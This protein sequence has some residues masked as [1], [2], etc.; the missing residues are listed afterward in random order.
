M[1][2]E[3]F[4]WGSGGSKDSLDRRRR[5]AEALMLRG[6]DTSPVQHWTQ[7]LARVG[8]AISGR[9][10][11]N[12][13]DNEAKAGQ[14]ALA[15][16]L[17]A[18][19]G[20]SAPAAAPSFAG[21]GASRT[22]AMPESVSPEMKTGI[23]D[24]AGALG[25][26]PVDLATV[27]SY[28]TGGS[29][30]P[31][32]AGPTTKWGQH[33]GLIQF[34]EPQAKQY[35]VDWTN[36]A[37]SQLG[38]N[39]AIV[40]Y[41]RDR[42]VKP[43]MGLMDIYSTVNAG[44]PGLY[45]RSDAAA[46]GAPGTVADKV[47]NQMSG[48]RARARALFADLPAPDARPVE[49]ETG[50]PGFFV[51]PGRASDA[52]PIMQPGGALPNFDPDTGRWLGPS[53]PPALATAPTPESQ[54][55][56]VVTAREEAQPLAP[57]FTAEGVTQPWMNTAIMPE[58]PTPQVAEAAPT[59]PLP[60]RRPADLIPQSE[61]PAPGAVPAVA[62]VTPTLPAQVAVDPN[63]P[64]GGMRALIAAEAN[65]PA[66]DS[67]TVFDRIAAAIGQR[68]AQPSPAAPSSPGV[69][70][71]AS[72]VPAA[73]SSLAPEAAASPAV[74]RVAAAMPGA[75]GQMAAAMRILNSPYALPGQRAVAQAVVER[76]LKGADFETVTR[77][78]GSVWRMPKTG[79]G[80]P[81]QVFG[82]Q[83][84]PAE[85]GS[86]VQ[87]FRD[88]KDGSIVAVD[89]SRV[90]AGPQEIRPGRPTPDRNLDAETKL[91]T[92]F[93]GRLK[94]FGTVQDAYGRIVASVENRATNPDEKSP[95]SDIA[96][97]FGY[98]KMLDPGSVVREGEYATAQNA[99][100]IPERI[101]NYYNK[102]IDGEF[103]DPKQRNDMLGTAQRLY[104]Q[105]RG[106]AEAEAKRYRDLATSY[107]LS[108]DRVV[109][110]PGLIEM[111][112]IGPAA[113]PA[114]STGAPVA[115][116][117][118]MAAPKSKADYDALPSGTPYMAPD[119]KPRVKP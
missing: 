104:K 48:H 39:G 105:A 95:A 13:L 34:G 4:V 66:G 24:A 94:E 55:A 38:A 33:R 11:L 87:L 103:L 77:P 111:P 72:A 52:L 68:D 32:Q 56:A 75:G 108:S 29:F 102:A 98:M 67:R 21:E 8:D 80:S 7:G 82:P 43:G 76:S 118:P 19:S 50:A 112:K 12:K 89:K 44:A 25:I 92:E 30:S 41:M 119:G 70:R 93:S 28:E 97:V 47:N 42:G 37:G 96:L 35:G 27:I 114:V 107:G 113:A 59:A 79:G 5:M 31:T 99:A 60:P 69:A 36:P 14:A 9:M 74:E 110:M 20:G 78:D 18:L 86:Q 100:G 16:D 106:S 71:I 54:A 45:D 62:Q 115:A 84:K 58:P 61:T 22:M 3:P 51:P 63:S 6:S 91:R 57:V 53:N 17:T 88:E 10:E 2:Q 73:A 101:R 116:P 26:S 46:G 15:G 81:V 85:P 23:A 83:S 90:G 40:A 1:A 117:A 109:A 65:A 49:A 64:D